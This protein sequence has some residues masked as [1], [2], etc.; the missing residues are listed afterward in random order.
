MGHQEIEFA[1]GE[2]NAWYHRNKHKHRKDEVLP[3]IKS[4]GI[5][6]D[7]VKEYGCADGWRLEGI[8]SHFQCACRGV[9]PSPDAILQGKRKY[10]FLELSCGSAAS[11]NYHAGCDLIIYGFCLYVCDRNSLHGIV[12]IGDEA[13]LEEGHLII[14]DFDPDHPHKVP[15]HHVDGL[16]SYKMDYSKLWLANP[17]YTLV[18][19]EVIPDGTAVWVLRKDINSGW[20][21]EHM[22][23]KKDEA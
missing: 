6:P 7:N 8:R 2:A 15:Y 5:I 1:N 13:L 9:D 23:E 16:F 20:P 11:T 14:H 22:E 21:L 3:I 10:P 17:A 18:H 4:L 12:R 19:K